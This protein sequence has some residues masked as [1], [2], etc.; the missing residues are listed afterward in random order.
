[1]TDLQLPLE[2]ADLV[3]HIHVD[4]GGRLLH[5][6]LDLQQVGEHLAKVRH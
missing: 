1:V 3:G 2:P 6:G 5:A 4:G